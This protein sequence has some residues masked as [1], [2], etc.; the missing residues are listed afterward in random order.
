MTEGL[1]ATHEQDLVHG[2]VK[3]SNILLDESGTAKLV[4][5]GMV[6]L[7][8][9]ASAEGLAG[10]PYYIS[11]EQA[12]NQKIDFRADMYSL[13]A[14]LYHALAGRPPFEGQTLREVVAARLDRPAPSLA[15]V[16]SDLCP[17]TVSTIAKMMAP[18]PGQRYAT[19]QEMLSDL[20]DAH[21][22]ASRRGGA[23]QAAPGLS[24]VPA[25][26]AVPT[27]A[28]PTS[29]AKTARMAPVRAGKSPL[30]KAL[31]WIIIGGVLIILGVIALVT[32]T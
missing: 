2:D 5:F 22:A 24:G 9:E 11:P 15:A 26:A 8:G 21:R 29:G 7:G 6:R 32:L 28:R 16:R 20:C 17:Q 12:Q 4:D 27:A 13:G 31:P 25:V 18:Q 1:I 3:P 14:T 10:T 23:P 30:E 19:Y